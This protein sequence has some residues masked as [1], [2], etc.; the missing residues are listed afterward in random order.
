MNT[1]T[2]TK[3]LGS[4]FLAALL[5]FQG[6][7]A[8]EDRGTPG[9]KTRINWCVQ[10]LTNFELCEKDGS[11]P[12]LDPTYLES[13]K[14]LAEKNQATFLQHEKARLEAER[15]RA[16][17][18]FVA[19]STW[20]V[21]DTS[22]CPDD[23]LSGPQALGR[24][25][26]VLAHLKHKLNS[27]AMRKLEE[28]RNRQRPVYPSFARKRGDNSVETVVMPHDPGQDGSAYLD[29]MYIRGFC[30]SGCYVAN[31]PILF[32]DNWDT[33]GTADLQIHPG[34]L[35]LNRNST[36]SNPSLVR[37]PVADYIRTDRI[38]TEPVVNI[39]TEGGRRLSVTLEHPVMTIDGSF[40][41]AQDLEVGS[42]LAALGE[43]PNV[44]VEADPIKTISES[45]YIGRVYNLDVRSDYLAENVVVA[46]GILNG[47]LYIQNLENQALNRLVFRSN[48]AGEVQ[49]IRDAIK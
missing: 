8:Q 27:D 31:Q 23:S 18:I 5:T 10:N 47:T 41:R 33:I 19:T 21:I 6:G 14:A 9:S 3:V 24:T 11:F 42:V 48:L 1:K 22:R 44:H 49:D 36:L 28:Y 15:E 12:N 29:G 37:I 25:D 30:T 38:N 45:A 39:V 2:E 7:T 34:I 13:L 17:G 20:D 4:V 43:V 16:K 32:S 40:V 46:G 26:W 35:V